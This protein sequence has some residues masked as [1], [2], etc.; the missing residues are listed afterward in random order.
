[1]KVKVTILFLVIAVVLGGYFWLGRQRSIANVILISMDTTRSDFLGCYGYGR[2][3]TPNIDA[4]AGEGFLFENTISPQ[5][6]TLPAHCSMLTGTVPPY[7]GVLDNKDYKLGEDNVVLSEI[8]K[9]NGF[10]TAGFVSS[11]VLDSQFGLDQGFDVYDDQFDSVQVSGEGAERRGDETTDRAIKWLDEKRGR[12]NFVFL[13]YFD[14]HFPYNAPEP[15]KSKFGNSRLPQ[16][17]LD[18]NAY[19]AEIAFTDHCIGRVIAKLKELDMYE[20]SLIIVTSDHGEGLGDHGEEA[21]GYFIYQETVKVVL[22]VKLPG[23]NKAHRITPVTGLVDIVPTVCSLLG[24][25]S[26]AGIQGKDLSPFF[27]GQLEP[28][29]DRHVYTQTLLPTVY[30][31]NPLLGVVNDKYK[32]IQTSRPE[33][34][35]LTRDPKELDDL[36]KDQPSRAR[37]MKDKLSQI[38]EETVREDEFSKTQTFLDAQGRKRLESLGYVAGAISAEFVFDQSKPNP[39]DL[40]GYH[41]LNIGLLDLLDRKKFGEARKACLEMIS[42]YPEFPKSYLVLADVAIG[43]EKYKQAHTYLEKALEV[44]PDNIGV[45]EEL[46][47]MDAK[48]EAAEK[49][50][51]QYHSI[52]KSQPGNLKVYYMMAEAYYVFEDYDQ[53]EQYLT[54]ELKAHADYVNMRI[55]LA[56][57]LVGKQQTKRAYQLC[58]GLLEIDP[59]SANLLNYLAWLEGTSMINGVRNPQLALKNALRACQLDEY[60][61]A[62][63][64]DTLAV[65]YGAVGD[66]GMAVKTAEKALSLALAKG[67]TAIAQKIEG[68]LQLYKA[69]TPYLE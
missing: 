19:A 20:T 29:A 16:N 39:K 21:H 2:Q 54:D 51:Q 59:E 17:H 25:E 60:R 1:M 67:D 46:A 45:Q 57:K 31:A 33:L 22:V 12:K 4:L 32:Y 18:E 55:S 61:Q 38:L 40:I 8:L 47:K 37:I 42:I 7:H 36:A 63:F 24:I 34:Y 52:L 10:T 13:H 56:V 3:T 64:V 35:D 48:F 44:A 11:F 68:R 5:P 66:F 58:L 50:I 62:A 43:Q 27:A 9:A 14:P 30:L 41:N 6:F 23:L 49:I 53:P 65:A 69:S 15:F 26:P 28:Y